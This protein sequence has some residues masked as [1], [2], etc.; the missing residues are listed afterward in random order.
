MGFNKSRN[1]QDISPVKQFAVLTVDLAPH[2]R[3]KTQRD[4]GNRSALGAFYKRSSLKGSSFE[5]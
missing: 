2:I 4:K 1:V 3:T 5:D